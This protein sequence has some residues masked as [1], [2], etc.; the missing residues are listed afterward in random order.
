[1]ANKHKFAGLSNE[2]RLKKL[3]A[4]PEEDID[5]S[6]IPD[7]SKSKSW[8]KLYP[9]VSKNIVITD[10]MIFD[11]LSKIMLEEEPHKVP[12]TIKL[13]QKIVDFFKKHSKKYQTKINDVL[14]A[15][16]NS[17]EKSHSH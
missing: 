14:L 15:F 2:E 1:M 10:Q 11:T 12:V 5:Y 4:M 3:A 16:V 9:T 13:D 7:M 8:K 6:D 17:Y